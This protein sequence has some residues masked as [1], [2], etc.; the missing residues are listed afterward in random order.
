MPRLPPVPISPQARLLARLRPGVICSS[1]TFFQSHSSSSATSWARP[2]IVPCPISER[3]MRTTQVSSGLI[4]TQML[5]S[6]ASAVLCADAVGN[7]MVKPSAKP[8]PAAAEPTTKARRETFPMLV[9]IAPSRALALRG[10]DRTAARTHAGRHMH[11]R[12]DA[13]I[14]ATAADVGHTPVH[15]AI[16]RLR[17]FLEQCRGGHDLAGLAIAALRHVDRE[18]RLL[19]RMRTVGRKPFD[20]DDLVGRLYVTEADRAGALHLAVDMDRA[21]AAL[22]DAAAEFRAGETDLL[23]D[24]PQE[25]HIRLRL[26]VAYLAIDVELGHER[27]LAR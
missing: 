21:C 3:A 13:L 7:G 8:P 23:P 6:V 25:R 4:A 18:P 17:C 26:H 27:P 22:G 10:R 5:T 1:V 14:G 16:G 24:H 15:A 2:V 19:H 20:R 9:M 12:A 11:G